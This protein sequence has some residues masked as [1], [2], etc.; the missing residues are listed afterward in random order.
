[1]EAIEIKAL[2]LFVSHDR[3]F[4][5]RVPVFCVFHQ[6]GCLSFECEAVFKRIGDLDQRIL[7]AQVKISVELFSFEAIE[8]PFRPPIKL[9]RHRVLKQSAGLIVHEKAKNAVVHEIEL[10]IAVLVQKGSIVILDLE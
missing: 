5:V 1:M 2:L 7:I 4:G 10:R 6:S 3:Q 8:F 9:N